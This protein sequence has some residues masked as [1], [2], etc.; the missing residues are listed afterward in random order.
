MKKIIVVVGIL[1]VF[2]GCKLFKE[3]F[4][5]EDDILK[6]VFN[7]VSD[8]ASISRHTIYGRF[9]NL[10]GK[11]TKKVDNL[12]LVLASLD[13][14]L[15]YELILDKK[16]QETTFKTNKLINEG[17]NLEDIK[18][19]TYI[20]L[21]KEKKDNQEL[22]YTLEKDNDYKDLEYYTITKN[23]LNKKITINF[24]KYEDNTYLKLD[25][26]KE[27]LPDT[28][29]DVVIDAGHGG[30]DV[31][32]NK[33]GHYE[34]HIN[35][36]YSKTLKKSLENLGLKVKLTREDDTKI[37]NYG[38]LSRV[39]IPYEVHAKLLLSIHQ[40]S[41][42]YNVG[43]G[44]VEVYVANNSNT[45]FAENISKNIVEL[46]STDY[47]T[48]KAHKIAPGVYLRTLSQDDILDMQHEALKEG[49]EPYT[50][51][52]TSST[53]YYIIR[54]TG[55]IVSGAYVDDSNKEEPW[56]KYYNSNYGTES[57]LLELGYLN[58]STNLKILLEEQDKYVEAI[59][60][61]VKEYLEI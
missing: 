18:E 2:T 9:L 51:A 49:Y 45:K 56:N 44:G 4:G 21:L 53:Y 36:S 29:Y 7:N 20:F 12:S 30:I 1:L 59:T 23:K 61:S 19:G 43:S 28:I 11:L 25:C 27:S 6:E 24:S 54:E 46:T 60:K 40:N 16:E 22:Y 50:L 48:N 42:Y 33:N 34:S 10:E 3:S 5:K 57:Y 41:A 26:K 13:E 32:A 14:T 52:N 38:D 39:S 8:K 55:G 37:P 58:S 47:S 15:E 35:L 31:G 17:I